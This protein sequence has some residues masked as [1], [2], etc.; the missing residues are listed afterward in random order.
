MELLTN[1]DVEAL[2]GCKRSKSQREWLT[3]QGINHFVRKDGQPSVTWHFVNN[4]F[5][6]KT[7]P[8]ANDQPDFGAITK[9]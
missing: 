4:P 8:A 9:L 6:A 7:K 5:G 2:S 1:E 3:A